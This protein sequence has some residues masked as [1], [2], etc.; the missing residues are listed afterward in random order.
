MQKIFEIAA[1]RQRMQTQAIAGA[2]ERFRDRYQR[3]RVLM[4]FATGSSFRE[5]SRRE[6]LPEKVV[7][8]VI[9]EKLAERVLGEAA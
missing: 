4:Q 2:A 9:R 5:V 1:A 3:G 8:Q 6:R 7:S